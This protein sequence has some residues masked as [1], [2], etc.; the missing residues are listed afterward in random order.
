MKALE[1]DSFFLFSL[2]FS[3]ISARFWN[4]STDPLSFP[5]FILHSPIHVIIIFC[6]GPAE[7]VWSLEYCLQNKLSL[8]CIKA[9][10]PTA[11]PQKIIPCFPHVEGIFLAMY[12]PMENTHTVCLCMCVYTRLLWGVFPDSVSEMNSSLFYSVHVPFSRFQLFF[13]TKLISSQLTTG[14]PSK[15]SDVYIPQGQKSGIYI[16]QYLYNILHHIAYL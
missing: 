5:K 15:K 7:A 12:M 11:R 9:K 6:Y 4:G 14:L 10:D 3:C 16:S 8:I 2:L 13:F 1:S